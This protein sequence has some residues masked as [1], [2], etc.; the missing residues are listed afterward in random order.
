MK[1]IPS[2]FRE[3]QRNAGI[4]RKH[5]DVFFDEINPR[6]GQ[7]NAFYAITD[8]INSK[9]KI[10]ILVGESQIGKSYL[11]SGYADTML[12]KDFNESREAT[13]RYM[14]FF[15]LELALRTAQTLGRMDVLYDEL[16]RIPHL[17]IDEMGRGKWSEFTSTFF[18]NLLIRRTEEWRD[19]LMATNLSGSELKEMLD[20]ALIERLKND[21]GIVL[22][23]GE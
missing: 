17:V 18:T 12:K 15:D 4:R 3:M 19:T 8:I 16:I 23:E 20:L 5:S 1:D 2:S 14:T 10:L 7:L 13:V 11:L 22:V 9:R 6:D 21:K